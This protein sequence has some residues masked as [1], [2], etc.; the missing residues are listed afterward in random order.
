MK[1]ILSLLIAAITLTAVMTSCLSEE[2]KALKKSVDE[3]SATLPQ[4]ITS[5]VVIESADY[6]PADSLVTFTCS[7]TNPIAVASVKTVPGA[8]RLAFIPYL[9]SQKS[10]NPFVQNLIA[11]GARLKCL[12]TDGKQELADFTIDSAEL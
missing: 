4:E 10:D 9:M 12:F 11:A 8:I 2:Q 3:Y 1:R 6:Q 7:V 5:G